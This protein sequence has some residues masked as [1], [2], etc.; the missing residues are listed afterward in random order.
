[1]EYSAS[2]LQPFTKIIETN[3]KNGVVPL[4]TSNAKLFLMTIWLD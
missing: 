4:V 1:M 2:F 3:A